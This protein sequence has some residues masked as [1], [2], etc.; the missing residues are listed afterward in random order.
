MADDLAAGARIVFA[1]RE[2]K[3]QSAAHRLWNF[4][5]GSTERWTPTRFSDRYSAIAETCYP[6]CDSA[7]LFMKFLTCFGV[8]YIAG[9]SHECTSPQFFEHASAAAWRPPRTRRDAFKCR[10]RLERDRARRRRRRIRPDAAAAIPGLS[11]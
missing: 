10:A 8:N 4:C 11:R 5:R 9:A 6:I 1:A 2:A 7:V 3:R